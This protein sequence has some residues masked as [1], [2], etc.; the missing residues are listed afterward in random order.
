MEERVG[1]FVDVQNL[2]YSARHLYHSYV[3]FGATLRKATEGRILEVAYAYV[4]KADV[5]RQPG[6]FDALKNEGYE[7][8]MKDIQTFPGGVQ[9]GNW[10]VGIAVDAMKALPFIDVVVLV[11]G[12]GDFVDLVQYCQEQGKRV[13]AMAFARSASG[14]LKE[15]VD[16]FIDLEK[17]SEVFLKKKIAGAAYEQDR[18]RGMYRREFRKP[19]KRV[20]K[21]RPVVAQAK[22]KVAPSSRIKPPPIRAP[23]PA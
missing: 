20:T 4:V 13:E 6:F 17:N 12:D 22:V 16:I 2:Y 5:P 19:E 21:P 23:K 14:K 3:D 1:V 15:A 8:R 10:D 18:P 7:L 11:T 9:K